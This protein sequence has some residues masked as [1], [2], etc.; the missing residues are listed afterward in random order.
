MLPILDQFN[1][2]GIKTEIISQTCKLFINRIAS[3]QLQLQNDC[4]VHYKCNV[5]FFKLQMW[6]RL[7]KKMCETLPNGMM[8]SIED[9]PLWCYR[10]MLH[11]FHMLDRTGK[12]CV[13]NLVL[14][15]V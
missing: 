4:A 2:S 9:L 14:R 1:S 6:E 12:I 11:R 15:E 8:P 7:Y 10:Y 13:V 5:R 3:T